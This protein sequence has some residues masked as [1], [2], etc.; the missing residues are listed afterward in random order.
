MDAGLAALIGAFGGAAIGFLGAI[1]VAADQRLETR[2]AERRRALAI[3]VGALTPVV[4][5]LREMPPN[6]E[7]DRFSKAIDQISGEQATW[8]RNRKGLVEI[9]PHMFG[10]QDR[11][12][13]AVAQVQLLDMPAE[14]MTAVEAA[15][16]YVV[17]L[18]EERTEDLIA[19]W[20][21]IHADLLDASRLLDANRPRWWRRRPRSS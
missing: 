7:P 13:S 20:P 2:Q 18:G 4:S 21:S 14:V 11:L 8:I 19:R 5:E 17:E 9:S 15:N 6:K 16:D 3:Y 10:R 12:S 1:K